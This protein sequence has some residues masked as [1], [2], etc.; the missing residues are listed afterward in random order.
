MAPDAALSRLVRR[1]ARLD[2]TTLFG[3]FLA[4]FFAWSAGAYL[5]LDA[6]ISAE[7]QEDLAT[8]SGSLMTAFG[9]LFAFLTAFVIASE[10]GQHRDAEHIVGVE[11]DT[12]VRMAWASESP[13]CDGAAIRASL[14]AYARSVVDDEWPRL[15]RGPEG[16][17]TTHDLMGALQHLIRHVAAET[18][19]PASV[20]SDLTKAANA[21]AIARADRLNAASHDLPTPLFLLTFLSGVMLALNAVSLSLHLERGYGLVISGLV[22]LIALDLALLVSIGAPFGGGL[23]VHPRPLVHV[24]DDVDTG[25]YG[26]VDGPVAP[27]PPGGD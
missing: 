5:V 18:D 4:W 11:A 14:A 16:S 2:S 6:I 8:L 21:M 15:E 3:L 27:R 10:W 12:W 1:L 7:H 24:L 20:S 26:R 23:G 25:R 9:A 22:V 17:P 19:I 13:G